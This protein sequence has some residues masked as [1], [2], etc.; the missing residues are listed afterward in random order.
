MSRLLAVSDIHGCF[1]TF[2]ELIIKLIDLKRTDQ[3]VLLGDYIDRGEQ[4]REVIDFIIDL[5]E[6]GFDIIA[7]RGNHEQML[8]DAYHDQEEL[9]LWL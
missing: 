6:K 5:T 7:L 1:A 2:Y 4:S 8:L 9:Y 3:L